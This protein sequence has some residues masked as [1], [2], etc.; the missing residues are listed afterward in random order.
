MNP[1]DF[2]GQ[3]SK[4]KVIMDIYGNRLVNTK[5]T[6]PLC[7]SS[8]NLAKML[9]PIDLESQF[10]GE[11]HDGYHWQMWGARGC[12]AL[13]CYIY[14]INISMRTCN[15]FPFTYSAAVASYSLSSILI[16][17]DIWCADQMLS[18]NH[19][20]RLHCLQVIWPTLVPNTKLVL[21]LHFK[22]FLLWRK[23][24]PLL[25]CATSQDGKYVVK[26]NLYAL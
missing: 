13:R 15:V 22:L 19:H 4:V 21:P 23:S 9:N 2:E 26:I 17:L 20:H 10:K 12:Y 5:E 3:R 7:I 6:K 16:I 11:G 24:H 8:S 14:Y 25:Q 1:I 18:W